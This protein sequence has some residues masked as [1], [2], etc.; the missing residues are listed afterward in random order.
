MQRALARLFGRRLGGFVSGGFVF[1]LSASPL[2]QVDHTGD[3]CEIITGFCQ[4]VLH[5]CVGRETVVAKRQCETRGDRACRW[6]AELR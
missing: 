2:V 1:E 5:D 4:R 3:A 6:V